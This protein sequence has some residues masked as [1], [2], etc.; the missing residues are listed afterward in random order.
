[1][2][3]FLSLRQKSKI[4]ATSLVRG[5]LV[6]RATLTR[7]FG[8]TLFLGPSLHKGAKGFAAY[9]AYSPFVM[10]RKKIVF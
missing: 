4:F 9:P 5:R 8:A 10:G 7:G 3:Y 1:L 6:F 2:L